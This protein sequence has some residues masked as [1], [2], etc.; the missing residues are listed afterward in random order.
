MS[1]GVRSAGFGNVGYC[2]LCSIVDPEVQDKLDKRVGKKKPNGKYSYSATKVN[3]YLESQGVDGVDRAVIYKHRLHV[4]HPKDR[5]VSAVEKHTIEKGVQPAQV[6]EDEFL[7]S[8]ISIGQTKIAADPD[9]VT[10]DQ[11]LKAVQIKKGSGKMGTGI[12]VL[13]GLMTGGPK[14]DDVVIEGEVKTVS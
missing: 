7:D 12:Q 4:Q 9:S 10:I 14:N 2:K 8:L 13:V 1:D 6:S 5:I 3:A 11:A